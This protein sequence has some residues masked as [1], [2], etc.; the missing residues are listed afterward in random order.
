MAATK[1]PNTAALRAEARVRPLVPGWA[2]QWRPQTKDDARA[3]ALYDD[4][5]ISGI[6][7]VLPCFAE[8]A[9]RDVVAGVIRQW[10]SQ[11]IATRRGAGL[12]PTAVCDKLETAA[13]KL[14][15][16]ATALDEIPNAAKGQMVGAR[17]RRRR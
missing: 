15:E 16:A 5:A 14:R 6:M 12:K 9:D 1:A 2:E 11:Q 10:A 3:L 13:A 8:G 4:D 7:E 17:A